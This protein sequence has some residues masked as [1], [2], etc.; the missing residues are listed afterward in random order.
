VYRRILDPGCENEKE[1]WRILTDKEIDSIDKKSTI[2][3]TVRLHILCCWTCTENGIK[4]NSQKSIV[5]EFGNNK[6]KKKNKK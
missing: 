2:T 4:Q 6:T 1:N 5:Y 3:E